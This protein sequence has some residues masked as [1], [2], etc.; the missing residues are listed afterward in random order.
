[1][2]TSASHPPSDQDSLRGALR[3]VVRAWPIILLCAAV[4]VGA[5]RGYET[6]QDTTYE[7]AASLFFNQNSYQQAIAGGSPSDDIQLETQTAAQII[8]LPI[9]RQRAATRAGPDAARGARIRPAT[10]DKSAVVSIRASSPNPG[11]AATVANAAAREY[12]SYRR[13]LSAGSLRDVRDVLARQIRRAPTKDQR[14]AL[15]AKL[16]NLAALQALTDQDVV[17]AQDAVG[18]AESGGSPLRSA[19]IA[20]VLG[21][22]VGAGIGM[23]RGPPRS[24]PRD[25]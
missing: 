18:A 15:V 24:T 4:A 6:Q 22:L 21:V 5:S 1:M 19:L 20:V 9:I 25:E 12:L 7:A 8:A 2:S 11:A 14:R 16:N 23:L 17:V 13:E 10:S 3:A